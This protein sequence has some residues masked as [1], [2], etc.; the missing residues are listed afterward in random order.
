[1]ALTHRLLHFSKEYIQQL[2]NRIQ[3]LEAS[4]KHSPG[5]PQADE[6]YSA[7]LGMIFQVAKLKIES[8]LH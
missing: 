8:N 1:M 5:L 6:T 2:E 7:T 4:L 3:S